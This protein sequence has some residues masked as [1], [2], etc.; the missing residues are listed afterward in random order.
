MLLK[1]IYIGH[2]YEISSNFAKKAWICRDIVQN[3]AGVARSN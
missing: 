3:A 1:R 2:G